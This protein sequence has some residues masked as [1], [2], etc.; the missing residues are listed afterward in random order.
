MQAQMDWRSIET[1]PKDGTRVLLGESNGNVCVGYY[2]R[3][4]REWRATG[5]HYVPLRPI[6]WMPIKPL[7]EK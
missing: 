7:P 5:S 1:A 4:F 6:Y 2:M 3:L